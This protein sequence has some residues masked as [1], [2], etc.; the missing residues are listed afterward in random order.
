MMGPASMIP[1]MTG[2][3]PPNTPPEKNPNI[4]NAGKFKLSRFGGGRFGGGGMG[5][6]TAMML[7][8][9]FGDKL[10]S[11]VQ[12][13]ASGAATGA[14]IGSF[15]PGYGTL[16]GAILGGIIGEFSH[17]KKAEKEHEEVVKATFKSSATAAEMF[18]SSLDGV[19]LSQHKLFDVK[20]TVT[21]MS[22][23][24]KYADQIGKLDAKDPLKIT[25]DALKT[26]EST[27]SIIGTIRTFAASQVS[28]GMDPSKVNDMVAALLTYAGRLDLIDIAQKEVAAR[29]DELRVLAMLDGPAG[30][31]AKQLLSLSQEADTLKIVFDACI[32]NMTDIEVY[33]RTW[34]GA[35]RNVPWTDTGFVNATYDPAGTF[36]ERTIDL[37]SME[38]SFNNVQ[39]KIVM[40][41]TE[42]A[43]VPMVKNLRMIASS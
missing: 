30:E 22:E 17:L 13:A 21:S 42:P 10:P 28:A 19:A 24:K 32:Q 25:A 35:F 31:S 4:K 1:S 27:K 34:S 40:K 14:S 9:M 23:I 18:G 7:L 39:L 15:F 29:G 36:T 12:G 2:M 20:Q 37:S 41:S 8:S 5:G 43:N 38:V 26:M 6:L 16:I 11:G 33:Y 3:V